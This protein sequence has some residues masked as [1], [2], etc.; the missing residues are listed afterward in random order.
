MPSTPLNIH[1]DNYNHPMST[2]GPE[3][4]AFWQAPFDRY[5]LAIVSALS[6]ILLWQSRLPSFHYLVIIFLPIMLFG[7]VLSLISLRLLIAVVGERLTQRR[8]VSTGWLSVLVVPT[9]ATLLAVSKLPLYLAFAFAQPT[10]DQV[11]AQDLKPGESFPI[12]R[13]SAGPYSIFQ[14]ARRRCHHKDRIYFRLS[15]DNEAGFVYSTSGIED[16]CYNSGSK[17]HLAD[18]W[19][20]WAED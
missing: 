14:Q 19:Y 2:T 9:L 10:L 3:P 1:C 18:N 16:L 7:A 20:W 8:A 13:A 17:G 15:N 4:L 12:S 6:A 5:T 11:I